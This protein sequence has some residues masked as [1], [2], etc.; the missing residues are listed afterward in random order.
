M[1]VLRFSTEMWKVKWGNGVDIVANL[2]TMLPQYSEFYRKRWRSCI[3][4]SSVTLHEVL[5]KQRRSTLAPCR[6]I[7]VISTR[8]GNNSGARTETGFVNVTG[9]T[10]SISWCICLHGFY[11]LSKC[12]TFFN[13]SI[14]LFFFSLMCLC[15]WLWRV[16]ESHRGRTLPL[17]NP[18]SCF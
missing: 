7:Q 12:Q 2:R 15:V 13:C 1:W 5:G 10:K 9:R 14:F 8:T 3:S 6:L 18:R 16:C 17:L 11:F 4:E